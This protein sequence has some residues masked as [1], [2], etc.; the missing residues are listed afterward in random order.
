V[1]AAAKVVVVPLQYGAGIKG[2]TCEAL[3]HSSTVVSTS[4]G[5]EGLGLRD[6]VEYLLADDAETFARQVTRVLIDEYLSKDLSN[7]ALSFANANL[8]AQSFTMR[9]KEIAQIFE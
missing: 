5:V 6:G 4:Y 7:A 1:Y 3:S 8:S 9:V 2:K